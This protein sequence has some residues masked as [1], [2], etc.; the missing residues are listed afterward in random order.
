MSKK[1][2]RLCLSNMIPKIIHYC[3]FGN[4]EIDA[5]SLE[6]IETWKKILPDYKIQVWNESNCDINQAPDFV[7]KAYSEKKWAFVSDYFR[8]HVLVEYGGIYLDTDVKVLKKF[9]DLLNLDFFC[10]FE[11]E[12]TLCTAI[13]GSSKNND[14]LKGFLNTYNN[15]SFDETPNSFLLFDYFKLTEFKHLDICK[16]YKINQN[17]VIFPYFY[18]S[19]IDFYNGKNKANKFT[20]CIHFYK[21]TWK[22]KKQ[23]LLDKMKK[24]FYNLIGKEN[25]IKIKNVI[26]RK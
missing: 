20:Y 10:S 25:Y 18:F 23:K 7:K 26:K 15:K 14:L 13:I 6:C 9:D 24:A 11:S 12:K 2:A 3:W 8:L 5:F 21:G 19:P 4:H 17:A 16:E 22:S 1:I